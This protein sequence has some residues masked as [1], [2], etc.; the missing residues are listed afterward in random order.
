MHCTYSYS[1]APGV[2]CHV[3][4]LS[5]PAIELLSSR[6][7][8]NFCADLLTVITHYRNDEGLSGII[9]GWIDLTAIRQGFTSCLVMLFWPMIRLQVTT[10]SVRRVKVLNV[11]LETAYPF[12][13]ACLLEEKSHKKVWIFRRGQIIGSSSLCW[14]SVTYSAFVRFAFQVAYTVH[15]SGTWLPVKHI[16]LAVGS[17]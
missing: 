12:C 10:L 7:Y 16:K 3:D 15:S 8:L 14:S 4:L 11:S 1:S 9:P 2:A 13:R 5:T 17:I 6:C